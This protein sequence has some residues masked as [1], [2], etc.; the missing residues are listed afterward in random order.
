M[1][2]DTDRPAE[3]EDDG[4]ELVIEPPAAPRQRT[5]LDRE[6]AQRRHDRATRRRPQFATAQRLV[7]MLK[8]NAEARSTTTK[9]KGRK[10]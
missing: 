2:S 4:S 3:G 1:A 6:E 7:A 5:Q 10:K 8:R 9:D